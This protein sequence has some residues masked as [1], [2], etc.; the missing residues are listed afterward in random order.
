MVTVVQRSVSGRETDRWTGKI[1]RETKTRWVIGDGRRWASK[2]T[3]VVL[4]RYLDYRSR[5]EAAQ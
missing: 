4:P 5:I 2:E 3:L 1:T